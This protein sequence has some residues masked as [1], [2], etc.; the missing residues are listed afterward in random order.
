MKIGLYYGSSTCYTE[1]AAEKIAEHLAPNK[2]QL[3][4]IKDEGL[5][6]VEHYDLLIF[7]IS[8]WDYGEL[9]EDWLE[10]WQELPLLPLQGKT[11]ALFGLGDQSGYSEWFLDALG[12]L[13]DQVIQHKAQ[14]VGYWPNQGYDFEQSR[15]LIADDEFFVGLALDDENQFE[16]TDSRIEA[17]C[18]QILEEYNVIN[19]RA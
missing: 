15:A 11:I 1:M 3:H 16:M 2:V 17:W 6:G 9:Q 12:L 4:N 19:K 10:L 13:H 7:G 8:T 14:V 5:V 18:K